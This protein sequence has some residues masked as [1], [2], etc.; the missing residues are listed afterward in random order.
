MR[1]AL[2]EAD[3][4]R[5]LKELSATTRQ[6]VLAEIG[7]GKQLAIVIA[8]KLLPAG[9]RSRSTPDTPDP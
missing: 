7:L 8:R 1:S 4:E 9:V 3:W 6:E 5:L 2:T